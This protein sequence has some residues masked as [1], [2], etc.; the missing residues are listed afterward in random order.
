V[1][2]EI[3]KNNNLAAKIQQH[4]CCSAKVKFKLFAVTS[5]SL[6]ILFVVTDLGLLK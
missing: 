5:F 3:Q 2:F 6:R 1:F 4:D